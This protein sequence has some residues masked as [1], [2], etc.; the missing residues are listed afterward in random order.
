MDQPVIHIFMRGTLVRSRLCINSEKN[1]NVLF[2]RLE[3]SNV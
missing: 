1:S 2:I 3:L